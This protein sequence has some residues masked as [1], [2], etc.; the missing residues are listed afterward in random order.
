MWKAVIVAIGPLGF[1][2]LASDRRGIDETIPL[3][4]FG[5]SSMILVIPY[6]L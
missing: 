3:G 2:F 5:C 4:P 1:A 6:I